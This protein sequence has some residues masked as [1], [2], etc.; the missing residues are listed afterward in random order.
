MIFPPKDGH[1][2][3]KHHGFDHV[4]HIGKSPKNMGIF[5]GNIIYNTVYIIYCDGQHMISGSVDVGKL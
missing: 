1:S 2:E 3:F 4:T 5:Y